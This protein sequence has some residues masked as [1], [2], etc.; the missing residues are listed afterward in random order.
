MAYV[1]DALG[2]F[3]DDTACA[4]LVAVDG[5]LFGPRPSL[6]AARRLLGRRSQ[7]SPRAR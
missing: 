4:T 5:V 2:E 7:W 1:T 3:Y 6:P